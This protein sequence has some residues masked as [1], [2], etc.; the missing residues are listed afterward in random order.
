[1]ADLDLIVHFRAALHNG[2]GDRR[3]IDAGS[4][5]DLHVV[6]DDD[7]ADLRNF[8]VL[9]VRAAGDNAEAVCPQNRTAMDKA[10]RADFRAA[11]ENGHRLKHA[12]VADFRV[13]PDVYVG[14][15]PDAGADTCA[16]ADRTVRSNVRRWR[17][18]RFRIDE[19]AAGD[20]DRQRI[21]GL[22]D[23]QKRRHCRAERFYFQAVAPVGKI[24]FIR[25]DGDV[26]RQSGSQLR[27]FDKA[28]TL[29]SAVVQFGKA[30]DDPFSISANSCANPLGQLAQSVRISHGSSLLKLSLKGC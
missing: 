6:A 19:R 11:L 5:A 8:Y 20:P 9:A 2:V 23:R 22:E 1:M 12:V 14:N 27:G 30:R 17:Y 4:G 3:P 10:P 24:L 15:Q 7:P 29:K 16:G 13:R 25:D 26:F 28:Q 18:D 21:A